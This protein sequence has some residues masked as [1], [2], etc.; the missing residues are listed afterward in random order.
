MCQF[1]SM[2]AD[3]NM[4]QLSN[5]IRAKP[6]EALRQETESLHSALSALDIS[7]LKESAFLRVHINLRFSGKA[8]YLAESPCDVL[9]SYLELVEIIPPCFG[10]LS[11]FLSLL[12]SCLDYA[13]WR[14]SIYSCIILGRLW[15]SFN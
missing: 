7:V 10:Y 3:L 6:L 2:R 11:L 12:S 14:H 9:L 13:Q 15:N 8:T 4:L 5:V 1:N